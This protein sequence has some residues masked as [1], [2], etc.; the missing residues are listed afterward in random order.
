MLGK[1]REAEVEV[2]D[3]L[4][5]ANNERHREILS[6]LK[7]D[8]GPRGGAT[9]CRRNVTDSFKTSSWRRL[10]RVTGVAESEIGWN[11]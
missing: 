2:P 1:R 11:L 3:V 5:S 8:C 7:K 6:I 10:F 4:F 9:I